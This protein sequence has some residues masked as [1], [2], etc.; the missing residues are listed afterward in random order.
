LPCFSAS[1]FLWMYMGLYL[2]MCMWVC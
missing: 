1:L 2:H